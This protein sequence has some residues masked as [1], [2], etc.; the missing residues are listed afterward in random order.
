MRGSSMDGVVGGSGDNG[1]V[2]DLIEASILL[3]LLSFFFC[4]PR[5]GETRPFPVFT[6][7]PSYLEIQEHVCSL[8][9]ALCDVHE[10]LSC[11]DAHR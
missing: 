5:S 1:T 9:K 3:L 7:P 6:E 8:D 2:M 4:S 11:V 10:L